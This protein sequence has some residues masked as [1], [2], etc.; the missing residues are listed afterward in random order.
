MNLMEE[1]LLTTVRPKDFEKIVK[2]LNKKAERLGVE[3]IRYKS[4][5]SEVMRQTKH[6]TESIEGDKGY[7]TIPREVTVHKYELTHLSIVQDGWKV[8]A[9]I[10]APDEGTRNLLEPF[11]SVSEIDTAKWEKANACNCDHCGQNRNRKATWLLEKDGVEKQ[12]GSACLKELV[13]GHTAASLAFASEVYVFIKD[14]SDE[15]ANGFGHGTSDDVIYDLHTVLVKTLMARKEEGWKDNEYDYGYLIRPGTHRDVA[16]WFRER[17]PDGVS[18]A[19]FRASLM[20]H[21][22]DIRLANEY[23][24]GDTEGRMPSLVDEMKEHAQKLDLYNAERSVKRGELDALYEEADK[25][26]EAL[27][28]RPA[29]DEFHETL[30]YMLSHSGVTSKKLGLVAYAPRAHERMIGN[31][32]ER[33][34]YS[35]SEHFGLVNER[36]DIQLECIGCHSYNTDWGPVNVNIFKDPKDNMFVWKTN[37]YSFEIGQCF[38][39]KATIK[40]HEDR[41]N[42]K[43][44][45]MFKQTQLTRVLPDYGTMARSLNDLPALPTPKVTKVRKLKVA[46]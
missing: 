25:V 15:A 24:R 38:N 28:E 10:L 26:I 39:A 5:G 43:L 18:E 40:G 31:D 3:P 37:A 19:D 13:D 35:K 32:L 22:R 30:N 7:Y 29:T 9:R 4:I 8:K 46:G 45:L 2:R 21:N 1:T 23:L 36:L 12:V 27:Q 16:Q 17:F 44:G 6:V 20:P 14:F 42:K 11:V 33:E 34:V 41:E